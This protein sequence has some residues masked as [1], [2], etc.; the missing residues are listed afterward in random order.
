M[1]KLALAVAVGASLGGLLGST[2]SCET[3]GCPL[4]ANPKRGALYGGFI[5]LLMAVSAG[6][7]TPITAG[8]A[9]ATAFDENSPIKE[10]DSAEQFDQEIAETSGKT[11]V[12]FHADWCAACRKAKPG[13]ARVAGKHAD[14]AAFRSVNTDAVPELAERFKVQYLPTFVVIEDGKEVRRMVGVAS[15]KDLAAAILP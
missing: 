5:G 10:V 9:T 7:V 12:Y 11:L 2:R 8:G 3:G 14:D 1:L 13:L 15:E 6:W 4:T